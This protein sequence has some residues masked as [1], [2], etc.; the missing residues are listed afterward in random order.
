MGLFAYMGKGKRSGEASSAMDDPHADDAEELEEGDEEPAQLPV[1]RSGHLS[2]QLSSEP[3]KER[4]RN[5]TIKQVVLLFAGP[6]YAKT[7][8]RLRRIIKHGRLKNNT[9]AVLRALDAWEAKHGTPP[10]T[11]T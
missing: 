11:T 2:G 3:S 9:E 8:E 6:E 10:V 7:V 5:A 4:Y 1:R